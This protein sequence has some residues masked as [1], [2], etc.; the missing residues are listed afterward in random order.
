MKDKRDTSFFLE[1]SLIELNSI[2][3]EAK[4]TLGCGKSVEIK[5]I[6]TNV[7]LIKRN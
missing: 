1:S 5:S 7:T 2:T 6:F 4:C 3:P